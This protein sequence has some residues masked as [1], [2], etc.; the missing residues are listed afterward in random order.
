[1]ASANDNGSRSRRIR[2]GLAKRWPD[3]TFDAISSDEALL[4]LAEARNTASKSAN[5]FMLIAVILAGLYVL[6]LNDL[7]QEI[8][9]GD[10]SLD[11]LPFGLF[12]LSAASL[13]ISTVSL[14]RIGDSRSYDRYLLLACEKHSESDCRIRYLSLPNEHAWGEPFS[15]SV[16]LIESGFVAGGL[17]SIAF[18]MVNLFLFFLS[19]API[20]VGVDFLL[21]R[22]PPVSTNFGRLQLGLVCFFLASNLAIFAL[23]FWARLADRD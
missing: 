11:K 21:H 1:M 3:S 20:L 13:V 22:S 7:G 6:R 19:I 15:H 23:V 10:Y 12:V 16:N 14:I 18:L 8:K 2:D 4:R 17:K 5:K 9:L